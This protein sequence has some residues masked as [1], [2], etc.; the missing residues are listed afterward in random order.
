MV[1]YY[2]TA[3]ILT[4]GKGERAELGYNKALH[5]INGKPMLEHSL[6]AF[7]DF[8]EVIV[9][10]NPADMQEMDNL[11]G[12]RAMVIPGGGTR[13]ESCY[14]GLCLAIN[15]YVV[16]H[17]AARP[18]VT[19]RAILECI[20]DAYKYSA[21]ATAVPE[22]PG[23]DDGSRIA[24]RDGNRWMMQT[25]QAFAK[26]IIDRAFERAFQQKYTGRDE[27]S[28]VEKA[29]GTVHI[30]LGDYCNRKLT[31]PHDFACEVKAWR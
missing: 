13:Q 31:F 1:K 28:L 19:E 22:I 8:D 30:T 6:D 2:L 14:R 25:P 12:H 11:A 29:G 20:S 21:S 17:D 9:V 23:F 18:Y 24:T 27:A 3:I 4:A 5:P 15:D 26:P 16:I 10:A 7:K